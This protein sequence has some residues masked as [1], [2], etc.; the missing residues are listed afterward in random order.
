MEKNISYIL[1]RG[2]KVKISHFKVGYRKCKT[3]SKVPN[4]RK[5]LDLERGHFTVQR[6]ANTEKKI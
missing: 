3:F 1:K 5:N 6:G 4:I 2:P